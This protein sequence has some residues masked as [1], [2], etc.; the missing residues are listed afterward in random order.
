MNYIYNDLKID[1]CKN[2]FYDIFYDIIENYN[3]IPYHS[4]YHGMDVLI[5]GIE[6]LK[7]TS[8]KLNQIDY[9]TF[10]FGLLGH[11]IKHPG[12]K[13][14]PKDYDLEY[15]HY[16][17]TKKIIEK[18]KINFNDKFLKKLILATKITLFDFEKD[19]EDLAYLIKL[20]D[21][22]HTVS[23]LEKHLNWTRKLEDEIEEKITPEKQIDFL[24]NYVTKI[25]NKTKN[26]FVEDYYASLVFNLKLNISFWRNKIPKI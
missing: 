7:N 17:E 12:L 6:F 15:F 3:Q 16:L 25:L 26:I 14:I 4:K 10:I 9:Q 18:H 23:F 8:I 21:I 20:A 13:N 22:N 11:D 2:K 5:K 1:M 19:F 24:E